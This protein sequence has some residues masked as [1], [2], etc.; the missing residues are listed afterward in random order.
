MDL[1]TLRERTLE[2]TRGLARM[3]LADARGQADGAFS[4]AFA[5]FAD[6][7]G[8]E[9]FA[10]VAEARQVAQEKGEERRARRLRALAGH[11]LSLAGLAGAAEAHDRIARVETAS[12]VPGTA[13][14]ERLAFRTACRT[15]AQTARRDARAALD[16][17][18]SEAW[19]TANDAVARAIDAQEEAARQRG[20]ASHAAAVKELSGIDLAV[21]AAEADRFLEATEAMYRD[22]LGWW[23]GRVF[24]RRPSPREI[25]RHDVVYAFGPPAFEGLLPRGDPSARLA[26]DFARMGLDQAASERLKI[27]VAE[28]PARVIAPTAVACEVPDE[29][30]LVA[31]PCAGLRDASAFFAACGEALSL[32][33][34]DAAR[35]FEDRFAGDRATTK[36]FGVLIG[37][38]LTDRRWLAKRL[39]ATAPDLVRVVALHALRRARRAA[40]LLGHELAA[41][42][43]GARSRLA[44]GFVDRMEAATLA[45]EP[46]A[47]FLRGLETPFESAAELRSLALGTRLFET[48]RERFDEDWWANPRTGPWLA[49]LFAGGRFD[50][51]AEMAKSLGPAP[52]SLGDVTRRLQALLE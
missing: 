51:A 41:H 47:F 35:P 10:R 6:V 13:A 44:R 45:R 18:L 46:A 15:V 4:E 42:A 2:L 39:E 7:V 16:A 23:L 8:V 38:W 20:F 11:L 26:V 21:L 3:E 25:E 50:G 30:H 17:S 36:A 37:S 49:G 28:A 48:A 29:V 22:V 34:T 32:T 12:T 19:S 5:P 43:Q 9:S 52:L 14:G 27:D 33:G 31:R 1:A 40:A 24:E